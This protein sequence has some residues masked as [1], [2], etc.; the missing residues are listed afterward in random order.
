[1]VVKVKQSEAKTKMDYPPILEYS[2]SNIKLEV[3][4]VS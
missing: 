3:F 4:L 2:Q 1:M